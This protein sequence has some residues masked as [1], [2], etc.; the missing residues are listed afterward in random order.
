MQLL[1]MREMDGRSRLISVDTPFYFGVTAPACWK[2]VAV[3]HHQ[4]AE[5]GLTWAQTTFPT[6]YRSVQ[7]FYCEGG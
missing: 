5:T 6:K 2:G 4:P 3:S 1:A 7:P